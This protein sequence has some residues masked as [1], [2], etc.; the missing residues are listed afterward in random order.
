[1]TLDIPTLRK[2]ISIKLD[3][4]GSDAISLSPGQ[5]DILKP[6]ANEVNSHVL[7]IVN[8]PRELRRK[9]IEA[10]VEHVEDDAIFVYRRTSEVF[11]ENGQFVA[12][13]RG[14]FNSA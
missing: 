12:I 2:L 5:I 3:G 9:I 4:P 1:M 10:T 7:R 11:V 14:D 13:M 6:H 8:N